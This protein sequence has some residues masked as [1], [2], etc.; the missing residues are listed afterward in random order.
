MTFDARTLYELLPA[1]YRIR[2]AEQGEKLAALFNL[3]GAEGG[4]LKALLSVIADQ[5]AVIEE[6]LDQLYDDQFVETA[7][8]W[9][10]PYIGDLIGYRALHGVAPQIGS[11]RAE[12][13]NT[14]A[15]RRRKGTAA[16][17][18][19][20]ARDVT[21][22]NA[23]V[24]EFFQLLATTQYMNHIRPAAPFTP[25]LRSWEKLERLGTGFDTVGH[26]IDVRQ[27][28][29]RKGRYNIPNIGIFL[30]RLSAYRVTSSPAVALDSR[31]F[32]ISP[33]GHDFPLFTRPVTEDRI[34]QIAQPVNVPD[35]ISRRVLDAHLGDYYGPG[36][37]LSIRANGAV[38][39]ANQVHACNLSDAG[40]GNWAHQSLG[41]VAID[42]VL[43]RLAFPTDQDP[44]EGVEV[45]FHYGF[46]AD[47]GGGQYE[48]A[49]GFV[50]VETGQALIRV[51]DDRPTIQAALDALPGVGGAVEITDSGRY[52][53]ALQITVAAGAEVTL[54][55]ANE[56]RP[57]LILP[58]A[59][60]VQGEENAAATIDGL[61]IAGAGVVV[62]ASA[63]LARL[64]IRHCTLVP[65]GTLAIDGT[66]QAPD[67]PSLTIE[68]GAT[69]VIIE[70]SILGG[71]RAVADAESIISDSIVDAT[72]PAGVAYS[73]LDGE[74][75]GAALTLT[76]CTVVGK[77]HTALMTLASNSIFLAA[78]ASGDGW[79]APVRALRKQEG[80][81]RFSFVPGGSIVP[82]RFRCQPELEIDAEIARVQKSIGAE[83]DAGARA[84]IR[85]R[86]EPCLVPAFT[87]LRYGAPAY[88]QLRESCPLQIRTGADDESEMGAFHGVFQPQ[89]ETN[90]RVRLDEYLRFGLEAGVFY[91]T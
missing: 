19:Q 31:R 62:P 11:P 7:A 23:R 27:I 8:E 66:P 22:Q 35:P 70:K 82:R 5:I 58:G 90:L 21:G 39:T 68:P 74:A 34:T 72:A 84:A 57:T 33:L 65:G 18:E 17:L 53:E 69:R 12:V 76:A 75:P 9:A 42:P 55:A 36:K 29:R 6:N 83:L 79:T 80:C 10:V 67:Q 47:M 3:D 45:T 87:T 61:L 54:R 30:W 81:V 37:S 49:D 71:I 26:T 44:P 43:G 25:D 40:G 52:E 78:L 46:S 63:A 14:I 20:L 2:D 4:P 88:G 16:M 48:R 1:I 77:V 15:Y 89:R 56:R 32:L 85:A 24:V 38:L 59:L 91:A 64:T 13:A 86:I 51:P 73:G 28:S 60:I 50:P 41:K